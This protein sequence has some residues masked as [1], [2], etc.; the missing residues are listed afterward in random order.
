MAR[1]PRR[2]LREFRTSEGLRFFGDLSKPGSTPEN[3]IRSEE[4]LTVDISSPALPGMIVR[5]TDGKEYLCAEFDEGLYVR[6]MQVFLITHKVV[7]RRRAETK[8]LVTGLPRS[9]QDESLGTLSVSVQSRGVTEDVSDFSRKTLVIYSP[10]GVQAN[11]RL[12]DFKIT[13]VREDLGIAI[14]E[15]N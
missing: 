15:A 2:F 11:D 5:T 8:D 13:L 7:W 10:L 14:C 4:L 1:F 12:G 9:D 6:R 3:F